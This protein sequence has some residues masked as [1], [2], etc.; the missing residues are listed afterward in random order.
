MTTYNRLRRDIWAQE[1]GA[2]EEAR[3]K[4][5][6]G[7]QFVPWVSAL[8]SYRSTPRYAAEL[9]RMA[10]D[11]RTYANQL[12]KRSSAIETNS[13]VAEECDVLSTVLLWLAGADPRHMT[14]YLQDASRLAQLGFWTADKR[15]GSHTAALIATTQ[16]F[17]FT[18]GGY[19]SDARSCL[20]YARSMAGS[21]RDKN[22]RVRVWKRLAAGNA[23]LWQFPQALWYYFRA[24]TSFGITKAVRM[25]ALM[26]WR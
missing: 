8:Y 19:Y 23:Q 7:K 10:N 17:L 4:Y 2:V 11:I 13:V 20:A 18:H 16:A 12:I 24:I 15:I 1:P 26:P 5:A 22:Q 14:W 21:I 6:E 9:V 3:K 25:K